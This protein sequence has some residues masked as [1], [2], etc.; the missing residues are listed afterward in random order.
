MERHWG[1]ANWCELV[2]SSELKIFQLEKKSTYPVNLLDKCTDE[3]K[4]RDWREIRGRTR[5]PVELWVQSHTELSTDSQSVCTLLSS[6]QLKLI[7]ANKHKWS[8]IYIVQIMTDENLLFSKNLRHFSQCRSNKILLWHWKMLTCARLC[9]CS[10]FVETL[11]PSSEFSQT[12]S[13]PS[14]RHCSSLT[15]HNY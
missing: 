7:G 2:Q 9:T 6:L 13:R 4:K 11:Y 1:T 15:S 5:V 8:S 12:P 10:P 3:R 14:P